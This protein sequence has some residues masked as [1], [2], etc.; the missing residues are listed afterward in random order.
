MAEKK[1]EIAVG[2]GAAKLIQEVVGF[3]TEIC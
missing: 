3:L 1:K 2:E